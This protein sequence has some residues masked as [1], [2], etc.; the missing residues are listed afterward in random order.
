MALKIKREAEDKLL[1]REDIAARLQIGINRAG[2]Y[3]AQMRCVVFPSGRKRVTEKAF[4]EWLASREKEPMIPR[5]HGGG[6]RKTP[7]AMAPGLLR[8]EELEYRR[9]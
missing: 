6:R 9:D 3:M 5:N 4:Q 2:Q 1:T 7:A 8:F